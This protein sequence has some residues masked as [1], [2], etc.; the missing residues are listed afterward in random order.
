MHASP[1][2][3]VLR[4]GKPWLEIDHPLDHAAA[5]KE[6]KALRSRYVEHRSGSGWKSLC[7]HGITAFHTESSMMYGY[8]SEHLAP[9]AWTEI[10]EA[11]PVTRA[12]VWSLPMTRFFRVRYM[13]LE[14]GASIPLHRD[15]R[16]KSLGPLNVALNNPDGCTFEVSDI[17][18]VPF[19]AGRAF[20]IDISNPHTVINRSAEDRYHL[21]VHGLWDTKGTLAQQLLE[22][23][24]R[25][26][27]AEAPGQPM[28][29]TPQESTFLR[30]DI[31]AG[32]S[33]V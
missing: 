32:R 11:C 31:H 26:S 25:H 20:L 16:S 18:T 29:K 19:A 1:V 33:I 22:S 7:I 28:P 5:F 17:G 8:Q 23:A 14:G 3:R 4:S 10:A 15:Q 24:F 6:A 12:W 30:T 9:H 13:L 21:I 2:Y 27:G